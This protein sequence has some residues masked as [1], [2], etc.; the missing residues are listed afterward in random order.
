M[1]K[2]SLAW[3]GLLATGMACCAC[4]A[5][6]QERLKGGLGPGDSSAGFDGNP[7]RR[8]ARV[9]VST[10]GG[11]EITG[12]IV[13]LRQNKIA[14]LPEPYW[15]SQEVLV[16]LDDIK[17]IETEEE[18]RSWKGNL[19]GYGALVGGSLGFVATSAGFGFGDEGSNPLVFLAASGA[20][21][22]TAVGGSLLGLLIGAGVD[23][24]CS[25]SYDFQAMPR[26]V[27]LALIADLTGASTEFW[28]VADRARAGQPGCPVGDPQCWTKVGRPD[29]A[30]PSNPIW[31]PTQTPA[32]L[33]QADQQPPGQE[34]TPLQP[35][36][37]ADA[38]AELE[39][40][41][42]LEPE[43]EPETDTAVEPKPE[44]EPIPEPNPEPEAEV[45][46][47]AARQDSPD[48]PPGTRLFG[49]GPP[50]GQRQT[51]VRVDE[52]GRRLNDGPAVGWHANGAKA[53]EGSYEADI[54]AGVWIYYHPNGAKAAE[55]ALRQGQ[56]D[57]PWTYWHPN[58]VVQTEAQLRLGRKIGVWIHRNTAGQES[59]RQQFGER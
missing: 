33:S 41:P 51:C 4:A 49:Q 23:A 39:M 22:L 15:R 43:I 50:M 18:H 40:V 53:I 42:E 8:F 14:I 48:C 44:P 29:L 27:Q 55:G 56:Q 37:A 46:T 5:G 10:R 20:G 24:A 1:G 2:R 6:W 3:M 26:D 59:Y 17:E 32:L 47:P 38:E 19:A 30:E 25:T 16:G 35:S 11:R 21:L 52:E 13:G 28:A 54:P 7:D 57:G 31:L 34:S 9:T 58:G 45:A 12:Q 36:A